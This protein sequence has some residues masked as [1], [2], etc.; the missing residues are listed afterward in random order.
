MV[1]LCAFTSFVHAK[2]ILERFVDIIEKRKINGESPAFA[3][4][5]I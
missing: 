4:D 2:E 3:V 1:E 5:K